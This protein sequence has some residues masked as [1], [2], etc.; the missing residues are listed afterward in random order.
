MKS[1]YHN[2]KY[3]FKNIVSKLSIWD[4]FKFFFVG[5][6]S[7]L[8]RKKVQHGQETE[9]IKFKN[10]NLVISYNPG[11]ITSFLEIF[12]FHEY[13]LIF[14]IKSKKEFNPFTFVDLGAN[15]GFAYVYFKSL[16]LIKNY[17]ACEPLENNLKLLVFNTYSK[18]TIIYPKAVWVDNKGVNFSTSKTSNSNSITDDGDINVETITLDEIFKNINNTEIFLKMDI[19]GAEYKILDQNFELISMNVKYFV[20]EFH[21]I[22]NHD[23]ERY[24]KNLEKNF[25]ILKKNDHSER[26]GNLLVFGINKNL[27]L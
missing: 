21:D 7:F 25:N 15:I 18:N 9:S 3:I 2:L 19:E 24:I 5:I 1:I 10:Q 8:N 11:D 14:K 4:N 22:Q 6:K 16:N 12:N 23:L 27:D 26:F 20:I 17:I 13:E